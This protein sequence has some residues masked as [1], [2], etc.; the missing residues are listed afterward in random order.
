MKKIISLILLITCAIILATAQETSA[1]DIEFNQKKGFISIKK[2]N[3]FKLKCASGY[4]NIYDLNTD[5]EI[6]YMYINENE[7][8]QN[9]DDDYIKV[10]FTKSKKSFETKLWLQ[11]I[12]EKL[13][14]EKILNS[15]WQIDSDRVDEFIAKYNENITNRTIR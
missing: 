7:T 11:V 9:M 2:I 13:I 8:P 6:M 12:M 4:C 15:N 10:Y 14:N 5:E 3:V 1:K